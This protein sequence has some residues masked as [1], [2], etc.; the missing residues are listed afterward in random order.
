MDNAGS[1]T[2]S[3]DDVAQTLAVPKH[4][5]QSMQVS[6]QEIVSPDPLDN[7]RNKKRKGHTTHRRRHRHYHKHHHENLLHIISIQRSFLQMMHQYLL[8]TWKKK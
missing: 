8:N 1:S 5:G 2:S 6:H 4:E 7:N 3:D